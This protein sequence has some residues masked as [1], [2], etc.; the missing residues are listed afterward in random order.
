MRTSVET[1]EPFF[2]HICL[3]VIDPQGQAVKWIK[4]K[5]KTNGLKIID[6]HINDFTQTLED[7]LT[8]GYPCLLHNIQ[9][10]LPQIID[11]ILMKSIYQHDSKLFIRIHDRDIVYHSSFRFYL[12][13]RLSNPRYK[14][15]LFSRVAVINFAIKEQG[16]EEQLL[17]NF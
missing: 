16:L 5:E 13:T 10:D 8:S 1:V 4:A 12:S 3:L 6:L 2:L 15:E 9:E 17:G 11:T 7:C 14:P